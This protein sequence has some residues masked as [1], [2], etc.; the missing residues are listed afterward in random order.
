[1]K[2]QFLRLIALLPAAYLLGLS[3]NVN[4]VWWAFIIAEFV[5]AAVCAIFFL[6]IYKN[7]IKPLYEQA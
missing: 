3:G 1:M 6:K 4:D 2:K 7:K 5:S